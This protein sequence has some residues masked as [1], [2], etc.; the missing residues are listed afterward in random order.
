VRL[1]L[2]AIMKPVAFDLVHKQYD[3]A[4]KHFQVFASF[5]LLRSVKFSI[6]IRSQVV[7]LVWDMCK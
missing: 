1:E 2:V 7:A 3:K 5:D 4:D 6:A